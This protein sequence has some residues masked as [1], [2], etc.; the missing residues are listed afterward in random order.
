MGSLAEI[1]LPS[2]SIAFARRR[3]GGSNV[4][5]CHLFAALTTRFAR[6]P[7]RPITTASAAAS[8]VACGLT[9]IGQS[10]PLFVRF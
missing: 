8:A 7:N 2:L 3:A 10:P 5:A 6:E 1:A 4:R 9:P